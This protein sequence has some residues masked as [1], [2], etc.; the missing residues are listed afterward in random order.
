MLDDC[1]LQQFVRS[2]LDAMGA[3]AERMTG[4]ARSI[5]QSDGDSMPAMSAST[6][7]ALAY[8]SPGRQAIVVL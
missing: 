2:I 7:L 3:L 1:R 8:A 6:P 5:A 4:R